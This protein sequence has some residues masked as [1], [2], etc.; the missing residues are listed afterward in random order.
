MTAR[1]ARDVLAWGRAHRF[2]HQ[3]ER[4]A[5]ADELPA[6]LASAGALSVLARGCGRSYGDSGLNAGNVLIDMGGLD[7]VLSFDR[8]TGIVEAEAGVT[9]RDILALTELPGGTRWFPPVV[10]GTKFVTVGGAIANDIHGKNHH[11]AGCFG[12]HVL[13]LRLLRSDGAQLTCSA[14]ENTDLFRATI[15][16]LGLTGAIL[17][18]RIALKAVTGPWLES[19][20]IRFAD[21]GAFYTLAQESLAAWE[22]TVAWIDCLA[23]GKAL[24]RGVFSR[25][26]HGTTPPG[27]GRVSIAQGPR[28]SLPIALPGFVLSAPAVRAFNAVHWRRAPLRPSPKIVPP[29]TALFPLDG[30]G[31]WNLMYGRRG[32][33]QYQCVVPQATARDAVAALL[34]EIARSGA[35]SFLAVL[36]T[37]GDRASPGMLS[38]PMPGTTLALDFPN[39]GAETLALLSRLDRVTHEAGGRIYP[40]KDGRVAAGDFQHC[41]PAWTGFSRYVDPHFSSSFWRRVS[42][43]PENGV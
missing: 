9:L 8:E 3:V 1:E 37:F 4:P 13:S 6:A 21:L 40:A 29:D 11:S 31:Q 5:F 36:K 33:Y 27:A 15:G 14:T 42:A 7:H 19:E 28:L 35:G 20:D 12:N 32:F 34:G 23:R 25:A 17:S 38:F 16:G 41:Y 2:V 18:A 30:I 10:P 43:V 39:R 22:Y 24:G 26:R